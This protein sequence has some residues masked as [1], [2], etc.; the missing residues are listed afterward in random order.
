M[1]ETGLFWII[2]EWADLHVKGRGDEAVQALETLLADARR[3]QSERC[4]SYADQW[5]KHQEILLRCGELSEAQL[6]TAVAVAKGIAA[7]IRASET[8]ASDDQPSL[9]GPCGYLVGARG[10]NEEEWQLSDDPETDPDF[11]S[12]PLYS[13]TPPPEQLTIRSDQP[14]PG[15]EGG[16][17]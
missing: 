16:D 13:L 12:L 7:A 3:K 15:Q 4:A 10:L 5:S 17:V 6:R 2:D 8:P 14:A 11:F 9:Y 1:S